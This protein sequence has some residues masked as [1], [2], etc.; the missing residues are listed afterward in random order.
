MPPADFAGNGAGDGTRGACKC[1]PWH[2]RGRA[3]LADMWEMG[4]QG[5]KFRHFEGLRP[6][7][8]GSFARLRGLAANVGRISSWSRRDLVVGSPVL[9]R[10]REPS[11]AARGSHSPR[12]ATP[13]WY[14]RYMIGVL[15]TA[16]TWWRE[17]QTLRPSMASLLPETEE[18]A[19]VTRVRTRLAPWRGCAKRGRRPR[20]GGCAQLADMNGKCRGVRDP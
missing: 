7:S 4:L 3:G 17:G 1:V 12:V 16:P 10:S 8:V 2:A 9:F 6:T 19:D 15:W 5:A 14:A 11:C 13:P 18:R 20:G